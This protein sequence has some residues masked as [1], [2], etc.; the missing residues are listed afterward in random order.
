[1]RVIIATILLTCGLLLA[2]PALAADT[3]PVATKDGVT[4]KLEDLNIYWLRNLGKDGLL[5]FFQTMVVYQEG[6]KQGLQPSA[7]E[8]DSFIDNTMGRDIYNEFKQLYSDRA[9]RQLVEYTLVTADY[10]LWLRDKIR[11]EKNLTVSESEAN[12]Y[13]LENIDLFHLPE[14]VYISIISVDNQTQA[15]SVIQRLEA[16]EDF[17]TVAGEVN[18]DPDMRAA[19]GEI[20]IYRRGEG[21][22]EPLENA[23]FDLGQGQHSEI[24][25][26][27]N[28]HIVYCHKHY[29]EV[30]PSFADVKEQL[31]L[32]MVEAK[33]DP[34]YIDELNKLMERELPRFNID[35]DLFRP[36]EDM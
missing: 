13:F 10:E 35:A 34:Y 25:K 8:V 20:G 27:Q 28:Y 31:M 2:L 16:G 36:S 6:L 18:M 30:A 12:Q 21:L 3:T 17:N 33:I 15:E 26:G 23:A 5:D 24:I 22:P 32:D 4:Y 19:R 14:G 11:N 7:Q 29:P 1:V 9:V